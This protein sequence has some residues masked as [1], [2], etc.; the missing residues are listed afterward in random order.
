MGFPPHVDSMPEAMSILAKQHCPFSLEVG[1][2]GMGSKAGKM[3]GSSIHLN[4]AAAAAVLVF[5]LAS[6]CL[7]EEQADR[8]VSQL[9]GFV[10]ID[11]E[12]SL[13]EE[14]DETVVSQP[15]TI[16]EGTL[17]DSDGEAL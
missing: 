10:G 2:Q 3:V 8:C 15:E 11:Q 7:S 13:P 9:Q 12:E 16:N 5:S 17:Q 14:D 6:A 1:W 4:A